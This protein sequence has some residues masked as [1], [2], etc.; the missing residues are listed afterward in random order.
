MPGIFGTEGLPPT[1][2]KIFSAEI[3]SEPTCTRDSST[4]RA[5]PL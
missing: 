5:C 4:K 1:F 3:T 2:T